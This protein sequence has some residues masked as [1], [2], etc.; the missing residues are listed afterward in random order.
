MV[1]VAVRRILCSING[2]KII[3]F[4]C[5]INSQS[6]TLFFHQKA[7]SRSVKHIEAAQAFPQYHRLV[8]FRTIDN[9]GSI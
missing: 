1:N 5:K 9:R 3:S 7:L 4:K 8:V 6:L 2:D